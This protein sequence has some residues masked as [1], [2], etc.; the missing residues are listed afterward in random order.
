MCV[1]D[2][3]ETA[4]LIAEALTELGYAVELAPDGESGLA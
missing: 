1:E 3:Q 4:S 2:D